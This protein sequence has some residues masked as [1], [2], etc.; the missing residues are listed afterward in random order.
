MTLY[1]GVIF[2]GICHDSIDGP[3]LEGELEYIV[4]DGKKVAVH[5]DC[6]YAEVGEEIEKH[7]IGRPVPHGGCH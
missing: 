3:H 6:Y 5:A 2:C 4:V 7:P 1:L